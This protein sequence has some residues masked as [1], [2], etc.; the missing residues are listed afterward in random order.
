MRSQPR[1]G[2]IINLGSSAATGG[3]VDQGAYAASKAGVQC[4]TET[5]ALEGKPNNVIAY[6]VVPRRTFTD[7]RL[8]MY[9]Q[10]VSH[11]GKD[12][13]CAAPHAG[14]SFSSQGPGCLFDTFS[15]G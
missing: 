3:R 14:L 10:E 6:C 5:V 12:T 15:S 11:L 2:L 9:P 7:M 13:C 4:L 8:S 1:G